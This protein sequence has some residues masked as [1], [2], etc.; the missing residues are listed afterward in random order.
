MGGRVTNE[1]MLIY[2]D[3]MGEED[4]TDILADDSMTKFPDESDLEQHMLGRCSEPDHQGSVMDNNQQQ[5]SVQVIVGAAGKEEGN[6]N[7]AVPAVGRPPKKWGPVILERKSTRLMGDHRTSQ[8]KA[9]AN[10]KLKNL[11]NNYTKKKGTS[12][13]TS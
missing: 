2:A 3:D 11:E 7:Q 9:K 5:P 12:S 8:K 10:K 4:T 6:G 13:K 1:P